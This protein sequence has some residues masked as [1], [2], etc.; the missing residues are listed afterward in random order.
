MGAWQGWWIDGGFVRLVING[1]CWWI[2]GGVVRLVDY[3]AWAWWIHGGL[4]GGLMGAW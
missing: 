4:A 3:G 2:D 1:A